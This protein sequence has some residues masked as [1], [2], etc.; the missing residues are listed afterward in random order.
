MTERIAENERPGVRVISVAQL[1]FGR[2]CS[3]RLVAP[4]IGPRN[5]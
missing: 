3:V 4:T 2:H 5:I 1:G